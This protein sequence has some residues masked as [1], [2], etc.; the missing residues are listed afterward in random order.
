M[1]RRHVILL[2]VV[3]VIGPIVVLAYLASEWL[4][5]KQSREYIA[6]A[7]EVIKD[8][9]RSPPTYEYVSHDGRI[10]QSSKISFGVQ[11]FSQFPLVGEKIVIYISPDGRRSV[12]YKE[13]PD[14]NL[15]A[16]ASL[17]LLELLIAGVVAALGREIKSSWKPTVK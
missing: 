4:H 2:C 8:N 15:Y 3:F 13:F 7:A 6:V 1:S 5:F 10:V 17:L 16:M 11:F 9:G 14:L 12:R